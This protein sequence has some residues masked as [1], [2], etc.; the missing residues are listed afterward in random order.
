MNTGN[1]RS[2]IAKDYLDLK[3]E[4]LE[5]PKFTTETSLGSVTD[6]YPCSRFKNRYL[7]DNRETYHRE[8]K[9]VS[10]LEAGINESLLASQT[11]TE[12]KNAGVKSDEHLEAR[13]R[14]TTYNMHGTK[15]HLILGQIVKQ[16][17]SNMV[18]LLKE[19]LEYCSS[20]YVN[21]IYS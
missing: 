11:E 19:L 9:D 15:V 14:V 17:V 6:D 1:D 3:T 2:C 21:L 20:I 16:H 7:N 5:T 8:C 10:N 4:G 12:E 18:S 13:G